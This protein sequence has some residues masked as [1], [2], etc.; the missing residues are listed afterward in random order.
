MRF[1]SKV[2]VPAASITAACMVN[3]PPTS[4]QTIHRST[5][6]KSMPVSA[7]VAAP[8]DYNRDVR[9]IL[10]SKCFACHG[11]DEKARQAGLRLD[12]R[13]S[14]TAKLGNGKLAIV[15]GNAKLSEVVQSDQQLTDGTTIM[16]ASR[17]PEDTQHSGKKQ[18]LTRAGFLEERSIKDALGFCKEAD[19]ARRCPAVR[20]K[21]W[22]R[23]GIDAFILAR[24]EKEGLKPSPVAD[25][26]T[27]IRRLSLDLIGIP[28]TPA[29]VDDLPLPIVR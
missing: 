25:R 6:T 1:F 15:P 12:L 18:I 20:L 26:P 28:P 14:A 11:S 7:P 21:T 19:T 24:L 23:N 8:L 2:F 3:S 16:R 17:Q 10:A 9:P 13:A 29:E 22:P 27:L 5:K 4:S